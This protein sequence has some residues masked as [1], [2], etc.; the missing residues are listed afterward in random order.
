MN[1]IVLIG[2]GFDLAH[3]LKTSY[4]DFI[5]WYW[6][7]WG[8]RLLHGLNMVEKD[9]LCSFSLHQNLNV[10]MWA[11]VWGQCYKRTNPYEPW[12]ENEIVQ[13]AKDDRNLC[14]F[15][16]TSPLL[17]ELCKQLKDRKWVDIENVYFKHLNNEL[18]TP[19]RV[20]NELSVIQGG[21]VNYLKE[22][23]NAIPDSL[24]NE[25]IRKK[26]KAPFKERDI[27]IGS[28]E[29]WKNMLRQRV[30]YLPGVWREL[31]SSFLGQ[32]RSSVEYLRVESFLRDYSDR[33]KN[34]G[35][36]NIGDNYIPYGFLLPDR[37]MLLNFNYTNTADIYLQ[38][39]ILLLPDKRNQHKYIAYRL[40]KH[41]HSKHRKQ[42]REYR[43]RNIEHE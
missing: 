8:R 40:R 1:R 38:T 21:L 36:E 7:E 34:S 33:I 17:E 20:N 14:D 22:I 31:V 18:E 37:V 42:R 19:E 2:N 12:D 10:G 32:D 29:H 25:D 39:N 6:K 43:N 27:A 23:Q 24:I 4:A 9:G 15:T 13:I 3:G 41:Q 35:I 11:R 26:M 28:K 16:I 30:D 5:D